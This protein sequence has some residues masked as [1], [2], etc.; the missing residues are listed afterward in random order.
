M[1]HR[2]FRLVM[3]AVALGSSSVS[4]QGV[5]A[6]KNHDTK[7][8]IDIDAERIEVRDKEQQAIFQGDVKVVQAEM[9]LSANKIRVFYDRGAGT[10]LT[11]RRIDAEGGVQLKSPSEQARA[12]YG[13]YDVDERQLTMVGNVILNKDQS[14]LKGQ[15]LEVNLE[16]GVTRLIGSS[17]D[18]SGPKDRVTGRF[19]VP[20][21][22]PQ[23]P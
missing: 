17:P 6:L 7:A 18:S 15:R 21:R 22:A 23:N 11:I 20:D 19:D 3:T 8:P 12:A 14:I 5:S 1:A 4:A 10:R 9:A 16:S 2:L 13:I